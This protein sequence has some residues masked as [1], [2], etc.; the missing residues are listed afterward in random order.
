MRA[1]RLLIGLILCLTV[2]VSS[3]AGARDPRPRS[4]DLGRSTVRLAERQPNWTS[5]KR[6][7]EAGVLD[8]RV[9][10]ALEGQGSVAALVEFNAQAEISGAL[11][12]SNSRIGSLQRALRLVPQRMWALKSASLES[13]LGVSLKEDF[14]YLPTSL[15][16]FSS[17]TSLLEFINSE[18][19]AAVRHNGRGS[20]SLAQSL[21]LIGQPTAFQAGFGGG[22][23]AVVVLDTGVDY[24]HAAFGSCSSPGGTGCKVIASRDFAPDDGLKDDGSKHGTNV[25]AIVSGVAPEAQLLVGDVF[26]GKS[27][28]DNFIL[29]GINWAIENKKNGI[30]VRA[31]NMSLGV[32]FTYHNKT[33]SGSSFTSAFRTARS[34]GILPVVSAGNEG[35]DFHS[36]HSFH[37][38]VAMPACTPGALSVAATYDSDI[39]R[40]AWPVAGNRRCVDRRTRPDKVVCW[41]QSGKTVGLFAPGAFITAAGIKMAGTSQAAPHVAGAVAVLGSA[42][43]GASAIQI[44]SALKNSGPNVYDPGPRITRTRLDIPASLDTLLTGLETTPPVVSPPVQFLPAGVDVIPP[45]VPVAA[46]WSA[47]DDSGIHEY[48]VQI[49]ENGTWY[50]VPLTT[51]NSTD[52]LLDLAVGNRYQFAVAARDRSGNWSEWAYSPEFVPDVYQENHSAISYSNGWERLPWDQAWGGFQMSAVDP[53]ATATFEFSGF[54]LG[55]VGPAGPQNGF[56]EIQLDGVAQD[57]VDTYSFDGNYYSKLLLESWHW[58]SA[59]PHVLDIS[60]MGDG[61][62]DVDAFIVLRP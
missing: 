55:W 58:T 19:V 52:L 51:G 16:R 38:G 61:Q 36:N 56:A 47:T 25:S 33:C 8:R 39:G 28:R 1:Y 59:A 13:V 2:T 40:M 24:R 62:I 9:V 4:L 35:F 42:Y 48:A 17:D 54:D 45:D 26:K 43:P 12:G 21:P 50:S 41:T 53:G 10:S 5:L 49:N 37:S 34:F 32:S 44:E 14:R 18:G 20:A 3:P 23:A 29:R 11:A 31:I 60:V 30:D 46:Q 27:Y 15:V 6:A 7:V 57:A 22:G